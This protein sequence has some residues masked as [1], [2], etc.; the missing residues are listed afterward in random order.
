MHRRLDPD[1]P[2]VRRNERRHHTHLQSFL[3]SC[4]SLCCNLRHQRTEWEPLSSGV[5]K[6]PYRASTRRMAPYRTQGVARDVR[7]PR[8][9][10]RLHRRTR[11]TLDTKRRRAVAREPHRCDQALR[12]KTTLFFRSTDPSNHINPPGRISA[13]GKSTQRES[14]F[15]RNKHDLLV[16]VRAIPARHQGMCHWRAVR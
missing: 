5:S 13:P 3:L 15:V 2:E 16:D 10:D 9:R 11:S 7:P 8:R 4:V 6:N 12:N 14:H 1:R